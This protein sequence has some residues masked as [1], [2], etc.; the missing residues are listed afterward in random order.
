MA[1]TVRSSCWS[2]TINNPIRADEENISLARQ[3]GW[4]V[5][6]QLE[7]GASGTPHY[8]LMVQTPQV[9]F[10]A[11]KSTFPRA[12]I[13]VARNAQALAQ[14]VTKEDTREAQL[15]IDQEFYPSY[16]KLSNFFAEACQA[17]I[18]KYDELPNEKLLDIFDSMV[19]QKIREGY[20]VE[21]M[22][23]NPQVRCSIKKF[24]KAIFRRWSA[25]QTDRQTAEIF[26]PDP[27]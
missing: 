15:S 13:E 5:Y 12:H 1:T 26:N 8:Q 18:D 4:K 21:S 14:Y 2:V 16:T 24:G 20:Y 19:D 11:V 9:R 6:G 3:K 7:K 22:A 25:R 10:S 17:Y 27:E 23:V